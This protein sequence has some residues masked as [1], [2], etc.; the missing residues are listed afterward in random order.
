[1]NT[2]PVK[3]YTTIQISGILGYLCLA[4]WI[5]LFTVIMPIALEPN[6]NAVDTEVDLVAA[7]LLFMYILMTSIGAFVLLNILLGISIAI[8]YFKKRKTFAPLI[9]LPTKIGL[10]LHL[11][12]VAIIAYFF[13]TAIFLL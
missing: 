9:C 8:E 11:T 13:I 6:A 1:M 5:F 3:K 4:F 12:P 7:R 10:F 2:L